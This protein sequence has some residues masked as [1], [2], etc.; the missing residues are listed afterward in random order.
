VTSIRTAIRVEGIVQGVGFL[1]HDRAIHIRT[2]DSVAR[3]FRGRPMLI[4]RSRGHVPEP[5]HHRRVPPP[6]PGLRR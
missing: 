5:R 2:D 1:T 4:R 6:G 3:T